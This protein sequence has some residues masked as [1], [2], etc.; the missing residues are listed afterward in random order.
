MSLDEV[1]RKLAKLPQM[2]LE[3]VNGLV[4]HLISGASEERSPDDPELY[5]GVITGD[6]AWKQKAA[7]PLWTQLA[8][9]QKEP[10]KNFRMMAELKKRLRALGQI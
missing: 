5:W 8:E 7:E 1:I 2:D 9:A 3:M 10:S 4:D 6:D